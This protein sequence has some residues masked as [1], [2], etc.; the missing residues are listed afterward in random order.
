MALGFTVVMA[1]VTGIVFGLVPAFQS[2]AQS[3]PIAL[4]EA[5]RGSTSRRGGRARRVIVVAGGARASR[6]STSRRGGRARRVIV[7]AEVALA[8]VLCAG[9]GLLIRSLRRVLDVRP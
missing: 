1:V 7:V 5:S 9:A 3:L 4:A 6:G 8:C 2:S